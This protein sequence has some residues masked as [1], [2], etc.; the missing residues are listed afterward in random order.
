MKKTSKLLSLILILIT[1]VFVFTAC[2]PSDI[3][4]AKVKMEDA[5]Y[6]VKDYTGYEKGEGVIGAITA[7]SV[8][9]GIIALYFNSSQEAKDYADGW[10]D[11]KFAQVE[12]EGRWAFAGTKKA[13]ED[14]KK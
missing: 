13:I 14:F 11:S 3:E 5:G 12:Y 1:T 7:I 8:S 2:V 10:Y 6:F 4:S 9:D